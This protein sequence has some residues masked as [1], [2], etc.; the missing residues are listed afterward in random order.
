ML[1]DSHISVEIVSRSVRAP[2]RAAVV[3]ET[4]ETGFSGAVVRMRTT[5]PRCAGPSAGGS[6]PMIERSA[7]HERVIWAGS[8]GRP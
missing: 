7:P 3:E 2:S 1:T 4:M 8:S 6:A 5:S